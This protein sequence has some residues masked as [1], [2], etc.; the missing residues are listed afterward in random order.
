MRQA[1]RAAAGPKRAYHVSRFNFDP[2]HMR[3][4][5]MK[6]NTTLAGMAF[7]SGLKYGLR[8]LPIYARPN[9]QSGTLKRQQNDIPFIGVDVSLSLPGSLSLLSGGF[10]PASRP[11]NGDPAAARACVPPANGRSRQRGTA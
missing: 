7:I 5:D 9:R 8:I 4:C 10:P 6:G 11:E 2:V 1:G 3:W